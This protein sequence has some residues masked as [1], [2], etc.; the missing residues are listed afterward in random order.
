MSS[1]I[2]R[3]SEIVI[4]AIIFYFSEKIFSVF[5]VANWAVEELQRKR[6]YKDAGEKKFDIE[7]FIRMAMTIPKYT[8]L[9]APEVKKLFPI[10]SK[11]HIYKIIDIRKKIDKKNPD[12]PN[13]WE[14]HR[15]ILF[16]DIT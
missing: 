8:I 6:G 2:K 10:L 5:L 12:A 9:H 16:S 11:E 14:L 7:D 15:K 13:F 3:I 1:K 4:L